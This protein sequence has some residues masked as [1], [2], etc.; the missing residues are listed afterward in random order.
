MVDSFDLAYLVLTGKARIARPED[1]MLKVFK[2]SKNTRLFGPEAFLLSQ[3]LATAWETHGGF[4]TKL[5]KEEIY[6]DAGLANRGN[7]AEILHENGAWV[8]RAVW[9][10]VESKAL[11]L[12]QQTQAR[13][14]AH[15]NR[16][17]KAKKLDFTNEEW[18]SLVTYAMK[19]HLA[20]FVMAYPTRILPLEIERLVSIIMMSP[21]HRLIDKA[22]LSDR[23]ANL[24]KLPEGYLKMTGDVHMGRV[25]SF[26][27]LNM[28][29]NE[30]VSEYM[31]VAQWDKITCDVCIRLDGHHFPV[32][33]AWDVI[34]RYLQMQPGDLAVANALLPFP[35]VKDLDNKSPEMIR[36]DGWFP[37]FHGRCRCDVVFLW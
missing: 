14:M 3:A 21:E 28:A 22:R 18:A 5:I 16:Q 1:I 32:K 23:L 2:S 9:E 35:K 6:L 17:R 34:L 29:V 30:N 10:E 8:G 26:T 33:P 20:A 11:E 25:W 36:I 13:A 4:L 12:M 27:G 7:I 15:F 31:I 24:D 19:D 37:P